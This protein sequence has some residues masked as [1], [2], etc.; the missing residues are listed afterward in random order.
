M[1]KVLK[2]K[3]AKETGQ[4]VDELTFNNNNS[5]HSISTNHSLDSKDETSSNIEDVISN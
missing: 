4:N 1:F 3:I 5:R 2:Q